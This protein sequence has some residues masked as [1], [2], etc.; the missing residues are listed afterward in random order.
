MLKAE[1]KKSVG[2]VYFL[3]SVLMLYAAF[4]L[5]DSG[6]VLPGGSSTVVAGAIW[7]KLHGNWQAGLGSSY[8][9]RMDAMWTDNGYLPVLMPVICGLPCVLP[10]LDEVRAGNK[11][12]ILVRSS[13]KKYYAAKIAAVFICAVLTALLSVAL[14]Y[15]TLFIFYDGI[16]VSDDL[17]RLVYTLFLHGD[18]VAES[19]D[20]SMAPVLAELL[21]GVLYFCIYAVINGLF[22]YFMAVCCRNGYVAFGGA[23]FISYMQRRIVDELLRKYI[24]EGAELAGK[25]GNVLDPVFLHCAGVN[26][27]YADKE[28]LAVIVALGMILFFCF[29]IVFV[30]KRSIDI[31]ER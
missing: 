26:G 17:F 9:I 20:V 5:G 29:M 30:S 23:V 3:I 28:A 25:I 4:L 15:V 13:L 21:K 2:S 7:N 12:M 19:G 31:G 8:L 18:M 6:Q 22:C 16:P 11:R 24:L 1:L 10:Y 14:Y 27:F